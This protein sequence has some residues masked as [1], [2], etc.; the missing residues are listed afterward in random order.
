MIQQEGIEKQR[1]ARENISLKE[2]L[3]LY[4]ASEALEAPLVLSDYLEM[5]I[6][7]AVGELEGDAAQLILLEGTGEVR[8]VEQWIGRSVEGVTGSLEEAEML[9]L[10]GSLSEEGG[11]MVIADYEG[12]GPLMALPLRVSH[13]LKK[14]I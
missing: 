9:R 7:V 6:D 10:A 13:G 4:R 3:A 2:S 11:A 5:V 1:L 12:Y 14:A 8:K